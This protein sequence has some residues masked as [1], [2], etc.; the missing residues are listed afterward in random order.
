[1]HAWWVVGS[2]LSLNVKPSV[3]SHGDWSREVPCYALLFRLRSRP[4]VFTCPSTLPRAAVARHTGC[5]G[6]EG[7]KIYFFQISPPLPFRSMDEFRRGIWQFLSFFFLLLFE[8]IFRWNFD[9]LPSGGKNFGDCFIC[10]FVD[11]KLAEEGVAWGW[12]QYQ[13]FQLGFSWM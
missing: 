5:G 13:V 3:H 1:M 11:S 10:N 2:P 7:K 12:L 8:R 6:A 9:T 4:L